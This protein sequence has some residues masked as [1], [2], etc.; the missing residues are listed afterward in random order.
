MEPDEKRTV[1][2]WRMPSLC[3]CH[4]EQRAAATAS[5][6]VEAEE[7][8]VLELPLSVCSKSTKSTEVPSP[9]ADLDFE[10]DSALL[11]DSPTKCPQADVASPPA[12]NSSIFSTPSS[13]HR[14]VSVADSPTPLRLGLGG[15]GPLSRLTQVMEDAA[16][17]GSLT[18]SP[19]RGVSSSM[20]SMSAGKDLDHHMVQA[21]QC[22]GLHEE[23]EVQS[24]Y[25]SV[26]SE[27]EIDHNALSDEAF[28]PMTQVSI[29][30][31]I[32]CPADDHLGHPNRGVS[33]AYLATDFLQE[34]EQAGLS[35]K[36]NI[37]TIE[38][39]VIRPRGQ[40][41]VCPR[42]GLKGAAYV[43]C[44]REAGQA[45]RANVMLS[46]TWGYTIADIVDG[47]AEYC[48]HASL[49]PRSVFVW[50]CCLCVNQHR[51]Q[52]A[53]EKGEVVPVAD[54]ER[55][56]G[57]RVEEIGSL[58]ALMAP[59]RAPMYI[60]RVWCN[61]EMFT[62]VQLSEARCKIT[63]TMPRREFVD[64]RGAL[65]QGTGI[66]DMWKMLADLKIENSQS[67]VEQD[68]VSILQ[69]IKNTGGIERTNSMLAKYL[70]GW[71]IKSSEAYLRRRLMSRSLLT[72]DAMSL[73]LRLGQLLHVVG[74]Y[75]EALRLLTM[76]KQMCSSNDVLETTHGAEILNE[77]GLIKHRS[78]QDIEA[79]EEYEAALAIRKC[80][81][82]V[83]SMTCAVLL[84][85][86]AAL[87]RKH[88]DF[89]GALE[90]LERARDIHKRTG[91]LQT[92]DGAVMLRQLGDLH[93]ARGDLDTA[94]SMYKESER[95]HEY[96]GTLRTPEGAG[97]LHSFGGILLRKGDVTGAL[98][99]FSLARD[100]REVTA[101]LDTAAGAAF[102]RAIG[103]AKLTLSDHDG[104]YKVFLE[105]VAIRRKTGTMESS[106]GAAL[107]HGLGVIKE[108]G[109]DLVKATEVY[110]YAVSI[111]RKT[112]TLNTKD[113]DL[114]L[115][116]LQRVKEAKAKQERE[117]HR[118]ARPAVQLQP[119][120]LSL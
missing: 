7:A 59:W 35:A 36:N 48:S 114:I 29:V 90:A 66:A 74:R 71:V 81:G 82:T 67:S 16:S 8:D 97:L 99:Q 19:R 50:M 14:H 87:K 117:A 100:I 9:E 37:Y 70:Q 60:N 42:T 77:L 30:E 43:D 61:Y 58:V 105:A 32:E 47:L 34:V 4:S 78:G 103:E 25:R 24:V 54:F 88:D 89:D 98:K 92:L 2:A 110:S 26:S 119:G 101:S 46:Y 13:F 76:A 107:L 104:A 1:K 84:R 80:T 109:G 65:L 64:F 6:K 23:V 53:K 38:P 55:E 102:L 49:H 3:A 17:V 68:R 94:L 15:R 63:I 52:E 28:S 57:S 31:K 86:I 11:A 72:E 40:D 79:L 83:E 41:V 93:K 10:L 111:R 56:F 112:G 33:L 18:P 108:R 12:L 118:A 106:G 22:L 96:T 21:S 115:A 44:L 5:R 75:H 120:L 116:D 51:V 85:N 113:G 69:R 27:T 20:S 45:S 62:A 91:T 39:A 73:H 95:T